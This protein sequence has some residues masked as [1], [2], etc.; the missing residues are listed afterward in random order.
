MLFARPGSRVQL[1]KR[2]VLLPFRKCSSS[3]G[4]RPSP[5]K[6]TGRGEIVVITSGK[7]GVGKTT[8]E[9][10]FGA[11]LAMKGYKTVLI[12]FDIG[13]RNLD[14]HLG[15][16]RRVVYDFVNVI[17]GECRLE[18]ALIKDRRLENLFLLAAS[19]T[20][21]KSALTEDGVQKVLD[22]LTSSFDF[23]VCDSP[24]GIEMGAM[25]AM[26]FADSAV[27]CTNP[28]LSSVRDSDRMIGLVMSKSRR[29]VEGGE[30]VRQMLAIT[31]YQ[32]EKVQTDSMI[33][34]DD[35]EEML[36]L[37]LVGVIPESEDV[38]QCSNMGQPV[39][40]ATGSEAGDTYDDMCE[41]FLGLDKEFRHIDVK[42]KSFFSRL[43]G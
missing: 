38:L 18:Q 25:H 30:P 4:F 23:V 33:S 29:A 34:V 8:S 16:E 26:Y 42:P 14:I 2:T 43:F 41:R 12:D 7:G 20:R 17:L 19:Q 27:I 21:D 22:E 1:C 40:L 39:I 31:R 15:M 13:L 11:G 10:S 37:P 5:L 3:Q 24:A 36:G 32:P 28:E 9:A 35:I 6:E